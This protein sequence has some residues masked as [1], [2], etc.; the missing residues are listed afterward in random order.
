MRAVTCHAHFVGANIALN[1]EVE[2][3][4]A[5][6]AMNASAAPRLYQYLEGNP[7]G[8]GYRKVGGRGEKNPKPRFLEL[9]AL[10]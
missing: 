1:A 7:H 8:C 9:K 5:N 10:E 2:P 6:E 3:S 4:L